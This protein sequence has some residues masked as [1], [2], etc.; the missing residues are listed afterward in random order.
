[1]YRIGIDLGGTNIA[2]GI[3][4]E[5]KKILHKASEPTNLPRSAESLADAIADLVMGELGKAEIS[6]EEVEAAGIGIPG[7]VNPVTGVVEY[8]NNFGFV[9]VPL[10]DLLQERLPFPLHAAN[11]AKAAAWGEYLAGAGAGCSSMLMITLGTGVGGAMIVNGS[12]LEGYNYAAGEI[13]HMVIRQGGKLCTCGRRGCLEAYASASALTEQA[14]EAAEKNPDSLLWQKAGKDPDSINGR[15]FMDCVKAG[16]ETARKVFDEYLSFLAEGTANLINILQP[17]R[18]CIG[19]GLS[20]AGEALLAPLRKRVSPVLYS[21]ES[22]RNAQIVAA[23]LGND[24]GII[25]AAF[26]QATD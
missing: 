11:D 10:K 16:D 12:C 4:D 2:L 14:R 24:A 21:R 15:L 18:V 23:V 1:M 26:W 3:A 25:G 8:A 20:G 7:T 19:G 13:G 22:E 5:N 17:E 9:N 6:E